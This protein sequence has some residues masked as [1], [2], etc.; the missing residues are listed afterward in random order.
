[1][2]VRRWMAFWNNKM[3]IL[4]VLPHTLMYI[5]VTDLVRLFVRASWSQVS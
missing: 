5:S 3:I 2:A 4:N 1:M